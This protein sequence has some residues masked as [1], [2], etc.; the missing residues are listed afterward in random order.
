MEQVHLATQLAVV[1][2]FGLFQTR[3]VGVQFGVGRPCRA[4]DALQLSIFLVAAPIGAGQLG[5]LERLAGKLGR[6]QVRP[7]AQVLPFVA[8]LVDGDRFGSR[9]V[10]DDLGL[11]GLADRFEM[12]DRF[13]AVP[14]L[15]RDL[16]I[17]VDDFAHALLD[18]RQVVE[19]ERLFAREVVIEAI[20]D[21][22][23]DRHLGAREQLLDGLGQDMGRVV[24]DHFEHFGGFAGQDFQFA[25][26]R[27]FA[28]EVQ[29]LTI[30]LDQ[31]G[32][33]GQRLRQ[34]FRNRT[35]GNPRVKAANGAIGERQVY[36]RHTSCDL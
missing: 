18:L 23:P 34:T 15:A 2:L 7:T 29:Q 20:L 17:A 31:D 4:V 14:D 12:L 13:G 9:Q 5:Q 36:H 6:R 8:V 26:V 33:F 1:A 16:F 32:L 10:A 3:D 28:V 19:R 25:G 27:Q 30:E 21:R 11:V 35:T 22:R 24:P